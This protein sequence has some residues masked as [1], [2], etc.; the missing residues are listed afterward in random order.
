[1]LTNTFAF[2]PNN[3]LPCFLKNVIAS[4]MK[5]AQ[6]AFVPMKLLNI[7]YGYIT[8]IEE[9][10]ENVR[11]LEIARTFKDYV[12]GFCVVP[13]RKYNKALALIKQLRKL[14]DT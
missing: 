7:P 9:K 6:R 8:Y 3:I 2:N 13:I 5:I 1:M 11:L 10:V 4:V 14:L 12:D